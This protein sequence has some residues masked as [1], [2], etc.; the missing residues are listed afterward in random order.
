MDDNQFDRFTQRLTTGGSRRRMLGGIL[1]GA[2]ALLTGAAGLE[3]K[4]DNSKARGKTKTQICHYQGVRDDGFPKY[5]VL[6]LAGPA[7]EKHLDVHELDTPYL[8]CCPGDEC[9]E[10]AECSTA[11]CAGGK[12]TTTADAEG[13]SCVTPTGAPG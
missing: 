6:S 13:V 5:K 7:A 8:D 4:P 2:A 12:C 11:A 9:P 10:A 1:V 3:A